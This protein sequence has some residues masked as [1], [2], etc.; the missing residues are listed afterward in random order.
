MK[1]IRYIEVTAEEAEPITED[2]PGLLEKILI[3]KGFKA[4]GIFKK[5]L[6]GELTF[7]HDSV[8]GIYHYTQETEND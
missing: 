2:T 5:R 7:W 1:T 3:K 4:K 8:T 6:L